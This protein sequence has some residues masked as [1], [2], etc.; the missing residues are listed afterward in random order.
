MKLR[1]MLVV[2]VTVLSIAGISGK[3]QAEEA[4]T[5]YMDETYISGNQE[6]PKVL[7]ILPWKNQQG[8]AVPA[9]IPVLMN[10]A[11]MTPIYPHEYR[12]EMSYRD[13]IA[14][15]ANTTNQQTQQHTRQQTQ[16]NLGNSISKNKS[17]ED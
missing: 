3:A 12:L 10:E 15:R 1:T 13:L 4:N 7:Y 11:V 6:L 17:T 8:D 16:S 14:D 9:M 2:A 5:V